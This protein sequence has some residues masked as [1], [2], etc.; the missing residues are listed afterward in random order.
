MVSSILRVWGKRSERG[1]HPSQLALPLKG[2]EP[3]RGWL[4]GGHG[5]QHHDPRSSTA[6]EASIRTGK[7]SLVLF[8]APS[9]ITPHPLSS[10][11]ATRADQ[12][13]DLYNE[14]E[15]QSEN[16]KS[17]DEAISSRECIPKLVQFIGCELRGDINKDR[18]NFLAGG[19]WGDA[20]RYRVRGGWG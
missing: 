3:L 8:L 20:E 14:Y 6:P 19:K 15:Y 2:T 10:K 16:K 4:Q 5:I 9:L 13:T 12:N 17:P 11:N 1:N 7:V 18:L